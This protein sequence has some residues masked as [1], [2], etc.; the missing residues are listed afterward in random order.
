MQFAYGPP[1]DKISRYSVIWF[2]VKTIVYNGHT[3]AHNTS[4]DNVASHV[5]NSYMSNTLMTYI[6]YPS[7]FSLSSGL[8]YVLNSL[9]A[10]HK[11]EYSVLCWTCLNAL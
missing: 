3:R 1:I 4:N 11:K 8:S 5:T 10:C 7:S 2:V 6:E 9:A